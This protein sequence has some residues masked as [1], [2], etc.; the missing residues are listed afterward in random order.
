MTNL[1]YYLM[2]LITNCI[3]IRSVRIQIIFYDIPKHPS[4]RRQAGVTTL[5]F[6]SSLFLLLLL[7]PRPPRLDK[8]LFVFQLPIRPQFAL[9]VSWG[10]GV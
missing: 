1:I 8:I 10:V 2:Y 7:Q 4:I 3:L 5:C 9:S 6:P